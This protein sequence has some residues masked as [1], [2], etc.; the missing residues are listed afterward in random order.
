MPDLPAQMP[1]LPLGESCSHGIDLKRMAW[2]PQSVNPETGSFTVRVPS[3][4]EPLE[5]SFV[6]CGEIVFELF[7]S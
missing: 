4:G 2:F 1:D 7:G 3:F 5:R 6:D